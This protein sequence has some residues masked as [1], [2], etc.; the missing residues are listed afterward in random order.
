MWKQYITLTWFQLKQQPI[1]SAVSIIGTSLSIFL[2]MLF[3]MMRQVKVASIAPESNRGRFLHTLLC[4][5]EKGEENT[6]SGMSVATFKGIFGSLTTPETVTS[7]DLFPATSLASIPGQ[8]GVP[9]DIKGTDGNF[10]KVFDFRFVDGKPYSQVEFNAGIPVAVISE[11]ISRKLFG[12]TQSAGREFQ[13]THKPYR[14]IG[15]VKDVTILTNFAYAQIWAPYSVFQE[16]TKK[17]NSHHNLIG[18]TSCTI[19]AKQK[20]DFPEIQQEVERKLQAYN[21]SLA[22]TGYRINLHNQPYNHEKATLISLGNTTFEPDTAYTNRIRYIVFFI[23]LIVPAI[24][25][26]SMT[27]S[28]LRQRVGEIG[29][30]RAFGCPRSTL[31]IQ[32]LGE[33]FI[34]TVAGGI[35][36]L[37]LSVVFGFVGKDFLFT[38]SMPTTSIASP[39]VHLDMLLQPSTFFLSLFFCFILNLMSTGIPAWHAARTHIVNALEDSIHNNR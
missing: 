19:L 24:N 38:D 5:A 6:T 11:S 16:T 32:L 12:T 35:L 10:W 2:I 27:Q 25:L 7:Y 39:E 8:H 9:A 33:N 26:S 20:S 17:I 21:Q 3:V 4:S 31:V 37:L 15:V 13:L 28:R 30:R 18:M 1:I 36:G 23:L 34:L 22:S 29:V 14:V